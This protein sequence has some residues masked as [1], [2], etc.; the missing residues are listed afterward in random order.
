MARVK[1]QR[2]FETTLVFCVTNKS[3]VRLN[4]FVTYQYCETRQALPQLPN[5]RYLTFAPTQAMAEQSG[6]YA[7]ANSLLDR[8]R[9]C[10]FSLKQ[11]HSAPS[12]HKQKAPFRHLLPKIICLSP[13]FCLIS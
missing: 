8:V 2:V 1:D 3:K 6:D 10:P 5:P 9:S 7:S 4:P 13:P 12:F 11:E